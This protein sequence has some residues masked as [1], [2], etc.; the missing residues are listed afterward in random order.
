MRTHGRISETSILCRA[1]RFEDAAIAHRRA[2]DL[3]PASA[4]AHYNLGCALAAGGQVK[5]AIDSYRRVLELRPD[6]IGAWNNLGIALLAI[7][8]EQ[9]AAGAFE[10]VLQISPDH[11]EAWNNLGAALL[12]TGK[13]DEAAVACERAVALAPTHAEAVNNLGNAYK[14]QGRLNPA[15]ECFRRA[16][17]LNPRAPNLHSNL[18]YALNFLP[19]YGPADIRA[20]ADCWHR[21]HAAIFET[22]GTPH[23]NVASPER[24]LRVGYVSPNFND[25][26]VGRSIYP[27]LRG[28]DRQC[29]EVYCYSDTLRPDTLTEELRSFADV[30]R[31]TASLNDEEVAQAVRHDQIDILVDLTLHM[32]R[33][34]L[35]VFARKPAPVQ[36]TYLGY[37]GT[38]G[39][40]AMDYRLSDPYFDPPETDLQAYREETVRLARTYWCY[41]PLEKTPE[42]SPLPALAAGH[43][44][45]GCLNNF[46]KISE[47]ALDLWSQILKGV[48]D[49]HLF[50]HAPGQTAR[51]RVTQRLAHWEIPADRLR[52]SDHQS[53]DRYFQTWQEIDIGLDPFPYGGG[54]TTCDAIWMGVPVVTLSGQTSVGRGGR[55]ILSNISLSDLVAETPRQY[56][57][58]AVGL[59]ADRPRLGELRSSLRARLEQSPLRDPQTFARDLEAAFRQMWRSSCGKRGIK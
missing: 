42:V 44:T 32:G 13:I 35:L 29:F 2:L 59:A 54:I 40:A 23:R 30:W 39:L 10:R 22:T 24:K 58:L 45:F 28:H 18:V 19:E 51:A 57:E 48:P 26:V 3:N 46:A 1:R 14:E 37:C 4:E 33:N 56:V 15:I 53:R 5:E 12:A 27:L 17:A 41:E 25:H 50:L 38:T 21:E 52:F 6:F 16:V 11:L 34:R 49:S 20:E 31:D 7:G 47:L 43:I 9:E 55:S 8:K 36:V